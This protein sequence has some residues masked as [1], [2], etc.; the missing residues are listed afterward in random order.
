VLTTRS[1]GPAGTGLLSANVGGR[2]PVNLVLLGGMR[3]TQR[4]FSSVQA[5][6]PV[7]IEG[8]AMCKL[9]RTVI[10]ALAI[11]F[12]SS[13][14]AV[15]PSA[16]TKLG[17]VLLVDASSNIAGKMVTAPVAGSLFGLVV[18]TINDISFVHRVGLESLNG[19]PTGKLL[20]SSSPVYFQSLD[21]TGAPY[22]RFRI[23]NHMVLEPRQRSESMEEV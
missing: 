11:S 7:P 20:F 13:V 3:L 4:F 18:M 12:S 23:R 21:C 17:A 14:V 2:G 19:R 15:Q 10:V 8:V 16:N 1:T 5:F 6:I 9:L 22:F